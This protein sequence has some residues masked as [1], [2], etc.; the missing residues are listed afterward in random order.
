MAVP[1]PAKVQ[2][3]YGNQE[4]NTLMTALAVPTK[5]SFPKLLFMPD[6]W[7]P[8]FMAAQMPYQAFCTWQTWASQF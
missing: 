4:A 5:K 2:A 6:H 3:H 8:Y 7:A 1:T